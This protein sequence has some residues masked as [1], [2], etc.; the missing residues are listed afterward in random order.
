[1]AGNSD[2]DL[3]MMRYAASGDRPFLNIL[4]HHDDAQREYAYDS[5]SRVGRLREALEEAIARGWAVVSMK[6]DWKRIFFDRAG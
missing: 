5:E 6:H 4:V 2:G 1:V 3:A